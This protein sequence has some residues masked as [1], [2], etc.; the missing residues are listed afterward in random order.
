MAKRVGV[1]LSG[2]GRLDGS[3]VAESILT[4]LVIERAGAQAICAAPD[5]DQ[6]AVVD[7]VSSERAG[8]ARNAW[9]EAARLAG[10]QIRPLSALT[11]DSI[12]ALIVPG[13]E[14][15]IATLSDYPEK[16]AL[17][18]I[19]PDV[20]QLLRALLQSRRPM[21]FIG[22]SALLA[23]RV[24]G[25]AAGVRLTLGSK[26]APA[27][28]HAAVMGADVRPCAPE[29]VTIDQKARVYSTPGFL[30]EGAQ[31]PSVARAV[32]RLVRAVVAN[33]RDRAP[34]PPPPDDF[35]V[36]GVSTDRGRGSA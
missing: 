30:A 7:H 22:L 26:G 12:D 2:C 29:D 19:Q 31:L 21:G 1:L 36:T 18:Q 24:L 8:G 27:A 25:P 14:G 35:D 10:P 9:A 16:H 15:P 5:A 23:A 17:C 11:V 20:A 33:A 3:D 13:G 34:A 32:D 28:K 4:L 6:A